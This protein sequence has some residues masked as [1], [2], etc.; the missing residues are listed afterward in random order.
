M[1]WDLNKRN[2]LELDSGQN[3][4]NKRL[5][6]LNHLR[7]LTSNPKFLLSEDKMG[8]RAEYSNECQVIISVLFNMVTT[9]MLR[10]DNAVGLR[11]AIRVKYTSDLDYFL[12]KKNLINTSLYQSYVDI[13]ILDVVYEINNFISFF[14]H[15]LMW[16]IENLKLRL[17]LALY[18]CWTALFCTFRRTEGKENQIK[19]SI[20]FNR[21]LNLLFS[22]P[23]V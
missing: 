5:T 18:F 3:Q 15:F 6:V 13:N 19:H 20:S 1:R 8:S 2:L 16:S 17:C 4:S 9:C 10:I 7:H 14:F 11:C 23:K 22:I 12:A 21:Y